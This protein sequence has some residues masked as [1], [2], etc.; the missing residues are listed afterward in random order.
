MLFRSQGQLQ[1]AEETV[2]RGLTANPKSIE[3]SFQFG[4]LLY[5]FGKYGEA[6]K[7]FYQVL[8][9][10][11]DHEGALISLALTFVTL[12]DRDVANKILMLLD[13][14]NPARAAEIRAQI[15][16]SGGG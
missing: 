12:G 11:P 13:V 10:D 14:I 15:R 3:L 4:M 9:Q 7:C 2:D 8:E 1:L 5:K 6:L 16:A